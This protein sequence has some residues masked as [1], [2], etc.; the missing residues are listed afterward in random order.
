MINAQGF[1][2]GHQIFSP[3]AVR[4]SH[5]VAITLRS[6]LSQGSGFHQRSSVGVGLAGVVDVLM[7][8][9]ASVAIMP[10]GPDGVGLCL[11]V[12]VPC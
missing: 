5:S 2:R 9:G 3:W 1:S 8:V 6:F 12:L 10:D 4:R 7:V 11:K